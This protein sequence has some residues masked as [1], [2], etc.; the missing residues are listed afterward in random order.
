MTEHEIV[1]TPLDDAEDLDW[2]VSPEGNLVEAS[3]S[4]S[5]D[6]ITQ[7]L[8]ASA[9]TIEGIGIETGL[10]ISTQNLEIDEAVDI[11]PVV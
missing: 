9:E 8:S 6:G 3:A 7:S 11:E 2:E 10:T 1:E 4:V 5:L